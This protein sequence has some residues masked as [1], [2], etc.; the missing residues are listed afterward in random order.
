MYAMDAVFGLPRKVSAGMS[1]RDPLHGE[2]LFCE[3]SIVDQFVHEYNCSKTTATVC[4][5]Y[6]VVKFII[7]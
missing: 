7:S 5:S 4:D 2:L 1:H 6:Y 3:Q